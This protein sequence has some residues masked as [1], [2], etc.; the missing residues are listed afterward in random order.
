VD[1][2][3]S[4]MNLGLEIFLLIMTPLGVI[5]YWESIARIPEL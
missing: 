1:F 5:V 4:Y 3:D 2:C